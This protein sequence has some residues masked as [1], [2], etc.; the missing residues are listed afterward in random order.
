[1]SVGIEHRVVQ[2][3][4]VARPMAHPFQRVL[5]GNVVAGAHAG[6][7]VPQGMELV[8]VRISEP[9][10]LAEPLQRHEAPPLIRR[11][12]AFGK[13]GTRQRREDAVEIENRTHIFNL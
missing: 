4:N 1:M 3:E 5:V 13:L 6:E 10:P 12:A 2:I 7:R 9:A 11:S 8:L